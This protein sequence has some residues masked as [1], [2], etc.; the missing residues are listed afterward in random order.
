MVSRDL[1]NAN[2][3]PSDA[4]KDRTLLWLRDAKS[5]LASAFMKNTLNGHA[6]QRV[7]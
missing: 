2:S 1:Q 3:M 4:T 5:D 7:R 6:P